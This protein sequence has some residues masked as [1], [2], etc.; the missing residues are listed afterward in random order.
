MGVTGID[1]AAAAARRNGVC[2]VHSLDRFVLSVPD[3]RDAERFFTA[4]G[5]EVRAS[6]GRLDLYT[7][8]HPQCWGA[9]HAGTG[10]GK[11]LEYLR[12]G[13][14]LQDMERIRARIASAGLGC[15]PHPLGEDSG[16]WL[17]SPDGVPLQL[18]VAPKVS[19]SHKTPH[20]TAAPVVAGNRAAPARSQMKPVR[21]RSLSHILC[22]T[23][24]VDR[25]I[26][27]CSV[28]LGLRLSDRS[29]DAIAFLHGAHGSDHHLIA[30]AKSSGPGLHHTSW[31]VDS[32]DQ[33]GSGAEQ[34]RAAGFTR[35]W[36]I[37]RHVL[38]S[39]Y[40]HY[41]RDPWGSWVE[42]S[43]D[44]DFVPHDL[45][46]PAGDHAAEDS[47]YAWGPSVPEDFTN[48]HEPT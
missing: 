42:Y 23:P 15:E 40:F 20:A 2:A 6:N 31:T 24:D 45:D 4:F 37:G 34:M 17:R 41:V 19:P 39:N 22:F 36:G 14:D 48:N 7:A 35:G 11:R 30:F 5:L 25:M 12:F 46:W 28:V 38:G 10:T 43:F 16:L 1:M 44:M 13:I 47:F 8:G 29:G 18:V 3:L 9:V 21:P 33:V 27:F 26:R 32:M